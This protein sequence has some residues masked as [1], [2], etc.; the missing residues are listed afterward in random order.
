[1]LQEKLR[2]AGDKDRAERSR[3]QSVLVVVLA[4]LVPQPLKDGGGPKSG[5]RYNRPHIFYIARQLPNPESKA[6]MMRIA[7]D[8]DRLAER[9]RARA[10][11]VAKE[12]IQWLNAENPKQRKS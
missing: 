2:T 11:E 6:V 1:V 7:T 4:R 9:A 8:Y 5:R 10:D 3:P 12:E